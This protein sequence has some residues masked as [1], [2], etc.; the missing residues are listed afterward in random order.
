MSNSKVYGNT[1]ELLCTNVHRNPLTWHQQLT[2]PCYTQQP[3]TCVTHL[4]PFNRQQHSI[5]FETV[6]TSECSEVLRNGHVMGTF[7]IRYK[8]SS[9][10]INISCKYVL[11][12]QSGYFNIS[13]ISLL[14][15][16]R[17]R[18]TKQQ[19]NYEVCIFGCCSLACL[20]LSQ[21][22]SGGKWNKGSR[23]KK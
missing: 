22:M 7:Q 5:H 16:A 14:S 23:P 11:S 15:S 10:S 20:Y 1:E 21:W 9:H 19:I 4:L 17:W 2:Y 8:L 13:C 6:V 3:T 18:I 12:F